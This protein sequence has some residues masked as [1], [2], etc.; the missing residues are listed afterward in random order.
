M[1]PVLAQWLPVVVMLLAIWFG[2]LYNNKRLDD[3]KDLLRAEVGT[4]KA[5]LH[6]EIVSLRS[7]LHIEIVSFKAELH[8]EIVSFKAELRA[9]IAR[10]EAALQAQIEGSKADALR[11]ET[12]IL[13]AIAELKSELKADIQTLDRRVQRLEAPLLRTS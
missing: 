12:R 5:E 9:E 13:Q 8:T 10:S 2:L 7:E 6:T 1:N 3:F 11:S 4:S